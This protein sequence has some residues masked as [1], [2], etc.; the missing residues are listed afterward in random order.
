MLAYDFVKD[1]FDIIRLHQKRRAQRAY[2][3]PQP[4]QAIRVD[5]DP[6]MARAECHG[7]AAGLPGVC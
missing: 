1:C 6:R 2:R 7:S 4:F 5:L 3:G